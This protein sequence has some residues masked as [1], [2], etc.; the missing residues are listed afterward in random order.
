MLKGA[1]IFILF[2]SFAAS[3]QQTQDIFS[4]QLNRL[5]IGVGKD[6]QSVQGKLK[7]KTTTET[8]FFTKVTLRETSN[9][10]VHH[11]TRNTNCASCYSF[12][13]KI[14]NP[15]V[16]EIACS[17]VQLW[18]AKIA[19]ALSSDNTP[20]EYKYENGD[21]IIDGYKFTTK[22]VNILIYSSKPINVETSCVYLS[23]IKSK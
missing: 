16:S 20:T 18:K 1:Y 9:N 8:V 13:A 17:K 23:I 10:E 22:G 5:I 12:S 4:K 15:T 21:D 19:S 14:I 2:L 3:G 6:L 11:L 7:R